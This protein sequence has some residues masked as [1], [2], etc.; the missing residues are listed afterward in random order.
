MNTAWFE[1]FLA[2]AA[3]GNF[4]RAAEERH[5]TQPAFGRR[6]RAL[7]EWLGVSLFDRSS[8]PVQLTTA[9]HWFETVART[10]LEQIARLP[11]EAQEV[12]ESHAATLKLAA[13]H[14]LSFTFVPAWL[15]SLEAE[16]SVGPIQLISDVLPRC[17]TLLDKR[18][19]HFAISHTRPDAPDAPAHTQTPGLKIGKDSLIP[20]SGPGTQG[21]ALH[22]LVPSSVSA[23]P[24]LAYSSDSGLGQILQTALPQDFP[25]LKLNTVFTAHLASVLRTMALAGRGVAWLPSSLITEDLEQGRLIRAGSLAYDIALDIRLMR[26]PERMG[27]AAENFWATLQS[28][29]Q[30][31]TAQSAVRA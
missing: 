23:T 24:F 26:Q 16:L 5:I 17:K 6:I 12:A 15:R 9:G 10:T 3:T 11:G 20:V 19:V 31:K 28:V 2:L 27:I 13:T 1:D 14:A 8:Q 7:E 29:Q 4:S 18:E 21:Q 25:L 30:S 22:T